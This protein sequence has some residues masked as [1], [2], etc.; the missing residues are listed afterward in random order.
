MP[1]EGVASVS[2]YCLGEWTH[3]IYQPPPPDPK[4]LEVMK[5]LKAR[6]W[7]R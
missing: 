6:E 1:K 5:R 2:V 4:L 7:G 3:Y